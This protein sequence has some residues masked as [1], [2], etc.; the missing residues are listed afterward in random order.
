MRV[1]NLVY[2]V[3]TSGVFCTTPAFGQF[4]IP[5]IQPPPQPPLEFKIPPLTNG[6]ETSLPPPPSEV[7]ERAIG[8]SQAQPAVQAIRNPGYTR[9]QTSSPPPP[10]PDHQTPVAKGLGDPYGTLTTTNLYVRNKSKFVAHVAVQDTKGTIRLI[11]EPGYTVNSEVR[12]YG[13]VWISGSG[14]DEDGGSCTWPSTELNPPVHDPGR[15]NKT[16]FRVNVL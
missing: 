12:H 16:S 10:P 4:G 9:P 7:I 6:T 8:Q 15:N 13:K 2:V 1:R 3:L 5:P 11:I 14:R